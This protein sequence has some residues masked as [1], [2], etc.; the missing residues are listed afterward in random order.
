MNYLKKIFVYISSLVLFLL[1]V[2]LLVEV[3]TIIALNDYSMLPEGV[4][5]V[6][7]V[8]LG[9]RERT[10]SKGLR[11]AYILEFSEGILRAFR[12]GAISLVCTDR[13]EVLLLVQDFRLVRSV[14]PGLSDRGE[15]NA[16]NLVNG[17]GGQVEINNVK[18]ISRKY[19]DTYV[20]NPLSKKKVT[21]ILE[22][23]NTQGISRIGFHS[24]DGGDA[25]AKTFKLSKVKNF[26]DKC[27]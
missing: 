22:I 13:D 21:S 4:K 5:I 27:Q 15:F 26:I 18:F 7:K 3:K 11:R 14:G 23:L 6:D 19:F 20:S 17:K 10:L 12:R 9:R 8:V 25:F 2:I 16:R 24:F 1:L